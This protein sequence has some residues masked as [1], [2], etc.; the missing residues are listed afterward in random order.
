MGRLADMFLDRAAAGQ[1][2]IMPFITAG[3]PSLQATAELVEAISNTGSDAIEIGIPFSDP[4]ADGPLI[5][6][7]MHA[8]LGNGTTPA[9]V[10]DVVG[11]V[12]NCVDIPL[13]AMVSVSIVESANFVYGAEWV[14]SI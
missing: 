3:Y 5:A 4:I 13:I 14:G 11:Q 1:G 7:T 9:G 10:F 12:R 2:A 8:S 6:S